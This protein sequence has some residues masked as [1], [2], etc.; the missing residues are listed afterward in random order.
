MHCSVATIEQWAAEGSVEITERA[1]RHARAL[2]RDCEE[3]RLDEAVRTITGGAIHFTCAMST[4]LLT[5]N[6]RPRT[7]ADPK[8]AVS[9]G[10]P[11]LK[12]HGKMWCWWS[13]YVDAA[14]FKGAIE[15]RKMLVQADPD[16]FL[17]HDHF[18][19]GPR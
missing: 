14:I 1:L 2:L 17:H 19:S 6:G 11:T 10:N 12:A 4:M 13:P 15:E 5:R 8:K 7:M 18:A 16:T 9:W 3:P